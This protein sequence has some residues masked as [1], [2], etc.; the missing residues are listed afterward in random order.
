MGEIENLTNINYITFVLT[1]FIILFGL[2]EIIEIF[3]YFKNKF[4]IKTGVDE[5]KEESQ[6]K[7][8]C[9][10]KR[11]TTLEKHDNWQYEKLLKI[12]DGVDKINA[13]ILN[14]EIQSLRW[15]LLD[16]CSALTN[17]REYNK[18]AFEHI[19]RTYSDYENLL[20]ENGL[21][22]GYVEESMKVVREIYHDRLAS[23]KFNI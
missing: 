9:F 19:F 14:N 21:T 8:E 18:E 15:E 17:G 20:K 5:D 7:V 11:I 12:S 2:K 13:S 3:S 16:F 10:E 23:G 22:N 1:L 4:R 6:K